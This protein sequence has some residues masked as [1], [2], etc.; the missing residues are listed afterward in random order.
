MIQRA[1]DT[2]NTAALIGFADDYRLYD[3]DRAEP[4]SAEDL[5][6]DDAEYS[7]LVRESLSQGKNAEGHVRT[8]TGLRVYAQF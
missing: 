2:I 5:G 3:S 4:V 7:S 8:S 6:I 1:A